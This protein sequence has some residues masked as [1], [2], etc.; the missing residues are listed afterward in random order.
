[1]ENIKIHYWSNQPMCWAW[2]QRD[3]NWSH[4][5]RNR[6][7]EDLKAADPMPWRPVPGEKNSADLPSRGCKS[8]KQFL[9]SRW[10]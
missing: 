2:I 6:V 7:N 8:K 10:W 3:D 4:F 1:M 9:S 5:V